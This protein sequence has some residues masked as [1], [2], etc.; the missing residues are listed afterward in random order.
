MKSS[1]PPTNGNEQR[2][3][4]CPT[5]LWTGNSQPSLGA[6]VGYAYGTKLEAGKRLNGT[7]DES[8]SK[9]VTSTEWA[10]IKIEN[11][12]SNKFYFYHNDDYY[13]WW[14]ITGSTNYSEWVFGEILW[15]DTTFSVKNI[16]IKPY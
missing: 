3:Y 15:S 10:K 8:N 5:T 7:T 14:T 9:T 6:F 16:K 12:G 4:W 13:T 1:T 2:I 11:Q